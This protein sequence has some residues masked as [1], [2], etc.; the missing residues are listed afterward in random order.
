MVTRSVSALEWG[1]FSTS[2]EE[3]FQPDVSPLRFAFELRAHVDKVMAHHK[4]ALTLRHVPLAMAI[5]A[6]VRRAAAAGVDVHAPLTVAIET[7]FG[8]AKMVPMSQRAMRKVA[9]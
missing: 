9:E 2:V 5:A 6:A 7:T 8:M 4:V 3:R 1:R